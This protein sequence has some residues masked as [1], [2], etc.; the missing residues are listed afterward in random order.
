LAGS[1]ITRGCS[2]STVCAIGSRFDGAER[3]ATV[4]FDF[5]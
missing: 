2:L 5:A 3:V 4:F 1:T